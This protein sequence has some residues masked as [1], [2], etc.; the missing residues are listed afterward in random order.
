METLSRGGVLSL[1][2]SKKENIKIEL[3]AR[4][5]LKKKCITLCFSDGL[6]PHMPPEGASNQETVG[7]GGGSE[8]IN[9]Y[10]ININVHILN[11]N[12]FE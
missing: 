7:L 10:V 5:S 12:I 8:H 1:S 6:G 4:Y 11:I 9:I 3:I 2:R